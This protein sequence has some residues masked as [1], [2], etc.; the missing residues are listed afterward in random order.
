MGIT[1]M[2]MSRFFFL[3]GQGIKNIFTHGFMSF[4]SV[5]DVCPGEPTMKPQPTWYPSSRRSARHFILFS[6]LISFGCSLA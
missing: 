4:A 5:A 3:L 6:K 2:R 1:A